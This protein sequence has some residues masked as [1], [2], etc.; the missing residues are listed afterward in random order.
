MSDNQIT[1]Y[2]D[3]FAHESIIRDQKLFKTG[4]NK[5]EILKKIIINHYAKYEFNINELKQKIKNTF[6]EESY[7]HKFNED[8]YLNVAWKTTKYL[9]EKSIKMSDKKTKHKDKIH[10]RKNKSDSELDFILDSCPKNASQSEYLVNIIYSYLKEPQHEREKIIYRDIINAINKAIQ[11]NQSIRIKTKS[12]KKNSG[13]EAKI[14]SINPKEICTSKEELYNYLLYQGYSQKTKQYYASTIH[15]YNISNVYL[16]I[17]LRTFHPDIEMQFNKMKRNGVQFS[18]NGNTV[19]KVKLTENG[20]ALFESRYLERPMPL[21]ESDENEGVYYFNCSKMQFKSYFA[22]F[23]KDVIILEPIE[24]IN[25]I[26]QEYMD[27]IDS[28]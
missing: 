8:F 4:K 10:M 22:P 6:I 9:C 26:V 17:N 19:Y 12:R 25:E 5:S 18:I 27:A 7:T 24:I 15:L 28:Y 14:K 11:N 21:P 23:R 2:L 20:K 13:N 3:S 1:I 16:D